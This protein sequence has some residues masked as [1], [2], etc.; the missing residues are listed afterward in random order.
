MNVNINEYIFVPKYL[1]C[2]GIYTFVMPMAPMFSLY[3]VVALPDP[4]APAKIQP[5]PSIPIPT[6]YNENKLKHCYMLICTLQH[7]DTGI[8]FWKL[9]SRTLGYFTERNN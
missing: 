2:C 4:Q 5:I 7:L 9:V 3:E 8:C 6:A 1:T